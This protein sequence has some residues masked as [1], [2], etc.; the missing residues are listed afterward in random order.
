MCTAAVPPHEL[1][2]TKVDPSWRKDE[3][4]SVQGEEEIFAFSRTISR[5]I[6]MQSTEYLKAPHVPYP[7][8]RV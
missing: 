4:V 7:H 2:P 6:E 1:Y 5:L 3:N 8:G